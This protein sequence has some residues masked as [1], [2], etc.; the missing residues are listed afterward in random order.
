MVKRGSE[1]NFE[2]S[3]NL[4]IEKINSYFG[5]DEFKVLDWYLSRKKMTNIKKNTAQM[6]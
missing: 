5:Y 2:Y 4:I 1:V 6:M 3:K